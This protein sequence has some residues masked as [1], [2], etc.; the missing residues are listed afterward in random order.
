[1]L[2]I[3]KISTASYNN[4][5][6]LSLKGKLWLGMKLLVLLNFGERNDI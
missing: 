1:M 3:D 2:I 6:M 5:L 4:V